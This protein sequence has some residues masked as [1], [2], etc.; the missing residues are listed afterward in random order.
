MNRIKLTLIYMNRIKLT[1][2]YTL[3]LLLFVGCQS[4]HREVVIGVSQSI[5]DSWHRQLSSEL[6]A[7]AQYFEGLNIEVK[8]ANGESS[9][10]IEQI[11]AFIESEVDMLVISPND[12]ESLVPVIERAYNSRIPI[13]IVNRAVET[14]K[15]TAFVGA[16]N[17][18]LGAIVGANIGRKTAARSVLELGNGDERDISEVRHRGLISKLNRNID[19]LGYVCVADDMQSVERV[20]DSLLG[21][22]PS[23]DLIFG[24]TDNIAQAAHN[25]AVRAGREQSI[26]FWGVGALAEDGGG[27]ELVNRGVLDATY[28]YATG[29]NQILMLVDNILSDSEFRRYTP[30]S[31]PMVDASRARILKYQKGS[32]VS[33]LNRRV[34]SLSGYLSS[35]I[36]RSNFRLYML[37]VA[38]A[39]LLLCGGFILFIVRLLK[40]KTDA[41]AQLERQY[42]ELEAVVKKMERVE[43][44]STTDDNAT[45]PLESKFIAKFYEIIEQNIGNVDFEFENIGDELCYSRVQ[46][47]RKVKALTGESPSRLLRKARLERADEL[48]RTTDRPIADI[49]FEVGFSAPSYFSKS[50]KEH[51]GELPSGVRS[52]EL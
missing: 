5:D 38:V 8:Y 27:V 23:V 52:S 1:L 50:Y 20:V 9:Y 6:R 39:A 35:H 4:G 47:Y 44:Q 32:E 34:E 28:I 40:A 14:D 21:V 30:L 51:F 10:Q 26:I 45:S 36:E 2:I 25:S 11:E 46:V 19:H 18:K 43:E 7:E 16:D 29:V 22:M 31:T 17:N 49:A 3:L 37:F 12:K 33:K 15:F 42:R 41:N 24:H 48:L 13:I